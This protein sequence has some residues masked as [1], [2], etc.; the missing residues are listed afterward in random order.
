MLIK[1]ILKKEKKV[2]NMQLQYI[3]RLCVQKQKTLLP[4]P[5]QFILCCCHI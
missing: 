3:M 4:L 1:Q 2:Y 5:L